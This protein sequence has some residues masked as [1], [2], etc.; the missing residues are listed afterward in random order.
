MEVAALSRICQYSTGAVPSEV[1]GGSYRKPA[2]PQAGSQISSAGLGAIISD[3]QPDD[4][5]GC[6]ELAVD[7]ALAILASKYS[8]RSP[9]VS[10]SAIGM[11]SSMSTTRDSSWG[12]GIVN[13][14]PSYARRRSTRQYRARNGNAYLATQP[15]TSAPFGPLNRDQRKAVWPGLKIGSSIGCFSRFALFSLRVWRSSSRRMKSRYVICSITSRWR[16]HLTRR[17]PRSCQPWT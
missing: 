7:P 2:V 3:H 17:H 12:V 15:D 10:R 5:A 9:F 11:L 13:R 14:A 6:A 1:L 8:Y 16:F 4:V